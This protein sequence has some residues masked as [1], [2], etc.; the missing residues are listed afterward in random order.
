MALGSQLDRDCF[1]CLTLIIPR[2]VRLSWGNPRAGSPDEQGLLQVLRN[3]TLALGP[4]FTRTSQGLQAGVRRGSVPT[5]TLNSGVQADQRITIREYR[6]WRFRNLYLVPDGTCLTRLV[7]PYPT[8]HR[9]PSDESETQRGYPDSIR[10]ISTLAL[11]QTSRRQLG[12]QIHHR[13]SVE[14]VL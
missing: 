3:C 6:N 9:D 4:N 7:D 8:W 12:S 14:E 11:T 5:S 10:R 13:N 2:G 1:G